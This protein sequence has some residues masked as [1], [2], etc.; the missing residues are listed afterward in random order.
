MASQQKS[1]IAVLMGIAVDKELVDVDK[2]VS[3]YVGLG[4][5][6][7]TADQE[8]QIRVSNIL[9]MDSGLD[10]KFR[11]STPAGSQ[12]HY[13]TPVYAISKKI[14]TEATQLP[15]AQI[16]HE[17]LTKPL[18][19]SETAWRERPSAFANVGNKTGLVTTPRDMARLGKL[20]LL[21]GITENG[22]RVVSASSI[23][24]MLRPTAANPA[25]GWLWWLNGSEYVVKSKGRTE[26]QLIPA[27]PADL[28]AALGF[29]DRR[30]YIVPSLDLV[31]V[32]T[33]AAA[34]DKD[35]DQQ[36]WLRIIK[37]I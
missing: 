21:G 3:D 5:S 25:Y 14:L 33:G 29:L 12:F 20:V 15:L 30:L 28:V 31:V 13:N 23:Q 19:M 9:K 35:F 18:D 8:A 27:A 34:S 2:P 7:A 36:L 11:F 22:K 17:W 1:F 10:D 37:T 6:K 24:A 4:W 16:T 32:R 26:G